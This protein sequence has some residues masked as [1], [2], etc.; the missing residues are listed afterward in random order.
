VRDIVSG[1]NS[2]GQGLSSAADIINGQHSA[3]VGVGRSHFFLKTTR[4]PKASHEDIRRVLN[5]QVG[6]LFPLPASELSFDFFQTNDVTVEGVLTVVAAMRSD[7]LKSLKAEL[8]QIGLTP[9]RILPISLASQYIAAHAGAKNAIVVEADLGGIS[10]DV[11]QNGVI[12]LSRI[13]SPDADLKGEVQR[14][15]A[16][17]K[18]EDPVI[19][20]SED[21]SLSGANVFAGASLASIHKA[22]AFNFVLEEE[23]ASSERVVRTAR[24][25][26]AGVTATL[27]L[28]SAGWAWYNWNSQNQAAQVASAKV[29]KALQVWNNSLSFENSQLTALST[30]RGALST[31]FQPAQPLSDVANTVSDSLPAGAWV[32]GLNLERGKSI[33]ARGTAMTAAQVSQFVDN[34]SQNPRFRDVKLVFANSALI[35]KVPVVQFYVT[36]NAVG[37]LAMPIPSKKS[38]SSAASSTDAAKTGEVQ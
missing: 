7:E 3:I 16:A 1:G 36:A 20:N 4:L 38:S 30:A 34:L 17:S 12:R 18:L 27:A 10:L 5:V 13:V 28:F 2:Q 19:L 37:N 15:V 32:T 6:Q 25:W 9:E 8:K 24:I 14:T 33:D 11:I 23:R 26:L 31:A 22:P 35:E 29:A 21:I